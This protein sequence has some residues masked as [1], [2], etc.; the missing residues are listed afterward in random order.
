MDVGGMKRWD[1][2]VPKIWVIVQLKA[3][4]LVDQQDGIS[5]DQQD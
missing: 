1:V 2:H 5:E 3:G 4:T